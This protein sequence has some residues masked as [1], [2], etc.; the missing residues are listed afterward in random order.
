MP[1]CPQCDNRFFT[2]KEGLHQHIKNSSAWHPYCSICDRHFINQIGYDSHM[3]ARHPPT[4]DCNS[5]NRSFHAQFALEDHYRGSPAH[6]NCSK[7]DRGFKNAHDCEEHHRTAHPRTSCLACGG[8]TMY[9]DFVDTHYLE[10]PNH[11][12]CTRCDPNV[13]F[14]DDQAYSEVT[15]HFNS[16]ELHCGLC[17][18]HFESA[19]AVLVHYSDSPRHPKCNTCNSGFKDEQEHLDHVAVK[20]PPPLPAAPKIWGSLRRPSVHAELEPRVTGQVPLVSARAPFRELI[21]S[22]EA[23][24]SPML[25]LNMNYASPITEV[26]PPIFSPTYLPRPGRMAEEIWMSRDNR[27]A[28]SPLNATSPPKPVP[29]T[30]QIGSSYNTANSLGINY[31]RVVS[32]VHRIIEIAKPSQPEGLQYKHAQDISLRHQA[33]PW[34]PSPQFNSENRLPISALSS[35][36]FEWYAT[37]PAS[38]WRN[39][40]HLRSPAPSATSN[41]VAMSP[42]LIQSLSPPKTRLEFSPTSKT[43]TTTSP[44]LTRGPDSPESKQ[45]L[46][47]WITSRRP[48]ALD[49]QPRWPQDSLYDDTPTP[50]TGEFLSL[51]DGK[52]GDMGSGAVTDMSVSSLHTPRSS[53]SIVLAPTPR[54]ESDIGS[55]KD[56]SPSSEHTRAPSPW[57]E[58]DSARPQLPGSDPQGGQ[59][60]KGQTGI[61]HIPSPEKKRSA[62]DW[63]AASNEYKSWK[64]S[65]Q[66]SIPDADGAYASL[67]R[68]A[69]SSRSAKDESPKSSEPIALQPRAYSRSPTP[70]KDDVEFSASTT[71]KSVSPSLR[72]RDFPNIRSTITGGHLKSPRELSSRPFLLMRSEEASGTMSTERVGRTTEGGRKMPASRSLSRPGTPRIRTTLRSARSKSRVG[73]REGSPD[74]AGSYSKLWVEEGPFSRL[75]TSKSPPSTEILQQA[76]PTSPSSSTS[77]FPKITFNSTCV[78]PSVSARSRSPEVESPMGLA[79]LPIVSPLPATPVDLPYPQ[80]LDA[81]YPPKDSKA[82]VESTS[83]HSTPTDYPL[84]ASMSSISSSP[85]SFTTSSRSAATPGVLPQHRTFLPNPYISSLNPLHCRICR[86]DVCHDITATMCGHIFC[87]DC[88]TDSVIKTSRCPVC[89]T[90]TLLYCLFRLDLTT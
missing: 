5:C 37:K 43:T 6:P 15:H 9:E 81:I 55:G 16:P 36:N 22:R 4:F 73:L 66:I 28:R 41:T 8:V 87:Y 56:S 71:P 59:S 86:T 32:F 29:S 70:V 40:E 38:E 47:P 31:S 80:T 50:L 75:N 39:D 79:A 48:F 84:A 26:K 21:A 44:T 65:R 10:S 83:P 61:P 68:S 33:P 14:K 23:A 88:I 3:A 7:C 58:L 24:A 34:Y 67:R 19:D 1:V 52:D 27:E 78:S 46:S 57:T 53:M 25:H 11:P 69:E 74:M 49:S 76:K 45:A 42:T 2:T 54:P 30:S 60:S 17:T 51:L 20:H 85:K 63:R 35:P 77:L 13:G 72:T 82:G 62:L 18:R 89:T 90:P 12:S 64:A